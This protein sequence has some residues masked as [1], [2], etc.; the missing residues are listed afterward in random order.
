MFASDLQVFFRDSGVDA[1]I[2]GVTVR[3]LFDN[4]FADALG[5]AGTSPTAL[6]IAADIDANPT[7]QSFVLDGVT[8]E[9]KTPRPDGHGM[10][11]LELEEQ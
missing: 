2:N 7:G 5:V 8:Y 1:L 11:V 4:G 9:V 3:V 10:V 6:C